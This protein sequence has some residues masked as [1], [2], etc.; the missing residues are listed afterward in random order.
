MFSNILLNFD[1]DLDFDQSKHLYCPLKSLWLVKVKVEVKE[2]V[3]NW[4]HYYALSQNN[5]FRPESDFLV[6]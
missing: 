2:Q 5:K 3:K 6:E 4:E 1:F